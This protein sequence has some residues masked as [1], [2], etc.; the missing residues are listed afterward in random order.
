MSALHGLSA[1]KVSESAQFV[2]RK[3]TSVRHSL[4]PDPDLTPRSFSSLQIALLV[5]ASSA[6]PVLVNASRA[7]PVL[8]DASSAMPVLCVFL[9]NPCDLLCHSQPN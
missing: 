9:P 1:S 8:V 4:S 2:R 6:M 5:D 3:R 7:M